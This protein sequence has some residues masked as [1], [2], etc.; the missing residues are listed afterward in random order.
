MENDDSKN[1]GGPVT[2]PHLGPSLP[3][4]TDTKILKLAVF[5]QPFP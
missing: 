2:V 3:A 5:S 4:E 1:P